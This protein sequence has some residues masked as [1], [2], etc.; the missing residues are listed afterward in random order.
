MPGLFEDKGRSIEERD[1]EG[2][3]K[4]SHDLKGSSGNLRN[5][6][7]YELAKELEK[8]AL[9][10]DMERSKRLFVYIQKLFH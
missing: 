8:N 3:A 10:H 2:L 5:N 9:Q 7:M 1:F 4:L 6:S